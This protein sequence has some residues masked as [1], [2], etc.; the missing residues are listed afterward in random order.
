MRE[1]VTEWV[2]VGAKA[3]PGL[4]FPITRATEV[5]CPAA[6]LPE[7]SLHKASLPLPGAHSAPI[8]QATLQKSVMSLTTIGFSW[9]V[10][11]NSWR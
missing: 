8:L 1:S 6:D 5:C 3:L 2:M 10:G 11:A 4:A 9:P 7:T